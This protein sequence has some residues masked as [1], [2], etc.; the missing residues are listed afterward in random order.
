MSDANSY[1]RT[2]ITKEQELSTDSAGYYRSYWSDDPS[3][4]PKSEVVKR[5]ILGRFFPEGVAGKRIMEVGVGGEGGLIVNLAD[6]NEVFG[7]DVSEAA[8]RNCARMGLPFFQA[9]L[10]SDRLPFLDEHFDI[11]FALEVFEHF[12]NPQFALEELRRV[13]KDDG[14][15]LISAPT[16]WCY[17]YPRLFY[18]S[19][20]KGDN[21]T[22]FLMINGFKPKKTNNW[23]IP[24]RHN[25]ALDVPPAMKIWNSFWV[26]TKVSSSDAKGYFELG[27]YFWNKI[28]TYGL[29]EAPLEALDL[30]RKSYLA[31]SNEEASL[32]LTHTLLYRYIYG[33]VE[34]FSTRFLEL[35]KR[36]DGIDVAKMGLNEI[37]FIKIVLEARRFG[38]CLVEDD[39]FDNLL[40]V[41]LINPELK[42]FMDSI[43]CKGAASFGE[44]Y[45]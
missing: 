15:L 21:F 5:E 10:D 40:K 34:E 7:V 39:L 12:A 43:C 24:I 2:L 1:I 38:I 41:A 22:E 27:A 33:D 26:S 29:R 17:H 23:F 19:L 32:Y 36:L 28:N 42:M 35:F 14:Q 44:K 25:Q 11:V 6:S 8:E 9:N 20:F 45:A 13:L 37:V 16:P 18:P 3:V 31:D 30:L 4:N